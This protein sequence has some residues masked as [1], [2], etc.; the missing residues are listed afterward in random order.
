VY[1]FRYKAVDVVIT[2][3]HK[4]LMECCLTCSL[5]QTYPIYTNTTSE[6]LRLPIK[7]WGQLVSSWPADFGCGYWSTSVT[8]VIQTTKPIVSISV[9]ILIV[10]NEY[11]IRH[12]K[13][14]T[15]LYYSICRE[16]W[17]EVPDN[18]HSHVPKPI[19][20]HEDITVLWKQGVQQIERFRKIDQI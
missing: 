4:L 12:D 20:E 19:S 1:S 17:I 7:P 8:W 10:K 2:L 3:V 6:H 14:F 11:I 13:V 9:I 15:Y 5:S 18:W 16:F